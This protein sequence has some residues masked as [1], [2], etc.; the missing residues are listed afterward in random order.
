LV[1]NAASASTSTPVL[2]STIIAVTL[3]RIERLRRS[4]IMAVVVPR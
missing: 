3:V 1:I 2:A 4:F